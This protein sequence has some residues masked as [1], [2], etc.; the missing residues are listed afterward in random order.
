MT[1]NLVVGPV[2]SS[3]LVHSGLYEKVSLDLALLI[4]PW[5]GIW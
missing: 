3:K 1:A 2:F 5:L 4:S